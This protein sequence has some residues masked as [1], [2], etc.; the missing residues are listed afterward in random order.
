MRDGVQR[1]ESLL[2]PV[3]ILVNNAGVLYYTLMKNLHIEEWQE[4]AD[5]NIKGVLNCLG[6]VLGKMVERRQGHIV[7]ISS[8]GGRKVDINTFFL[9]FNMSVICGLKLPASVLHLYPVF[10]LYFCFYNI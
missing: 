1:T 10:K 5:V 6:A 2:G 4:I 9:T 8:D 7:N 3:D